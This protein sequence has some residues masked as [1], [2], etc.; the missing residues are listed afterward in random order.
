MVI[1]L[2][3]KISWSQQSNALQIVAF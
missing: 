3:S 1:N 2:S